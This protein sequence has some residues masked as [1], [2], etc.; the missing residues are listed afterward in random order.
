ILEATEWHELDG[1]NDEGGARTAVTVLKIKEV[2]LTIRKRKMHPDTVMFAHKH[3]GR[4][5]KQKD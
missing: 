3:N 1:C 4:S 5:I 2:L